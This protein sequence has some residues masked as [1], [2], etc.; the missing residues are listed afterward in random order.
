MSDLARANVPRVLFPGTEIP[1][2]VM[3]PYTI[4][5]PLLSAGHV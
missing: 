2:P 4:S 5:T 1:V 3:T